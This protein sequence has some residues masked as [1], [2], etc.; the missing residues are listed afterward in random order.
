M[1][2]HHPLRTADQEP[3]TA[4]FASLNAAAERR[5]KECRSA[6][7]PSL[8]HLNFR[9]YDRV[10]EPSDDTYLLI[11]AIGYDVDAMEQSEGDDGTMLHSYMLQTI[12]IGCGTGTPTVYL[13]KRIRGIRGD[14]KESSVEESSSNTNKN[15]VHY[16]T[17]INPDAIR[18]AKATAESNGIST[19]HFQAVQCDL[20]SQLTEKME[21]KVDVLIFNPPYVPTPDDEVGSSGIE[22]SWAGGSNGRVVI[23]RALPQ[24]A[25]LL[26][27]PNGVAYMVTVDDNYPEQISQAMDELYGIKVVPWLRRRAHNEY[28]TIQRMTPTRPF[29]ED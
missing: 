12:E 25:R 5:A 19:E 14:E 11:D 4:E 7:M 6:V 10:Y 15:C 23:D 18:I 16:V 17:D 2:E 28:L 20:A 21:G 26:A 9:D 24:I 29:Q 1:A 8:K 13:A 27:F 22:A 3:K